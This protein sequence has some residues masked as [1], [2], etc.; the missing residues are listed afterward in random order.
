MKIV[1]APEMAEIDGPTLF[2]AGGITGCPDWQD[3]LIK[4][5]GNLPITIFNPRRSN[6]NPAEM[7][8]FRQITWEHHYLRAVDAVSFWFPKETLCPI[9]LF[10]YGKILTHPNKAM[11]VAVHPDYQRK[12]DISCQT[13]LERPDLEI[14]TNLNHLAL[15]IQEWS[16]F[17]Q[18]IQ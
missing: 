18:S 8:A 12:V 16:N 17:V 11:F 7:E 6:W 9:T 4:M 10:E 2:L 3:V 14:G 15:K 13:L 1:Q 5:L